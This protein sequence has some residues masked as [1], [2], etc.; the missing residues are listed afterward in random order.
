MLDYLLASLQEYGGGEEELLT[1]FQ[2]ITPCVKFLDRNLGVSR[3]QK[4]IPVLISHVFG[5][6]AGFGYCNDI[7][8]RLM[9]LIK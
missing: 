5:M 8:P 6:Q 7:A 3:E 1:L 9:M 2:G 4:H